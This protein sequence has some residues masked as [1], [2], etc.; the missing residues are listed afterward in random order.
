MRPRWPIQV[1]AESPDARGASIIHWLSHKSYSHSAAY[2]GRPPAQ[3]AKPRVPWATSALP[4]PSQPKQHCPPALT[5]Q[6]ASAPRALFRRAFMLGFS[7]ATTAAAAAGHAGGAWCP[8]WTLLTFSSASWRTERAAA[9]RRIARQFC[10]RRAGPIFAPPPPP[11][12]PAGGTCRTHHTVFLHPTLLPSREAARVRWRRGVQGPNFAPGGRGR[13]SAAAA[14]AVPGGGCRYTHCTHSLHP[15]LLL[16]WKAARVRRRCGGKGLNFASD[17]A[18]MR[19][20]P[21]AVDAA[22]LFGLPSAHAF[23]YLA[24]VIQETCAQVELCTNY[25]LLVSV[26]LSRANGPGGVLLFGLT[27]VTY[28]GHPSKSRTK[29]VLEWTAWYMHCSS[30]TWRK[31]SARR[32]N[33]PGPRC[34]P[35]MQLRL[36]SV[37]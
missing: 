24:R 35:L 9:A 15:N 4:A 33:R 7:D 1:I 34:T 31:D 37:L 28:R 18:A 26:I 17:R 13:F 14:A 3:V 32:P 5:A 11:P 10:T 6:S 20:L 21:S 12:P 36:W 30:S 22:Q 16:S 23:V 8:N 19:V 25:D 29:W 2:R 27:K